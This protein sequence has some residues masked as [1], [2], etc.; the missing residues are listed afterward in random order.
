MLSLEVQILTTGPLRFKPHKIVTVPGKLER[1]GSLP[2]AIK[3][4]VRIMRSALQSYEYASLRKTR[5]LQPD[6]GNVPDKPITTGASGLPQ[7]CA[8]HQGRVERQGT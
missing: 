8:S 6:G 4:A 3:Q 2:K 5:R 7:T 1:P